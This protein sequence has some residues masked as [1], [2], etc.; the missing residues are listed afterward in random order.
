M[1]ILSKLISAITQPV[2]WLAVW[3]CV[4]LGL[5]SGAARW[6]RAAVRMLWGG[7][8]VLGLLGYGVKT[9]HAPAFFVISV[10]FLSSPWL[11]LSYPRMRVSMVIE[12]G[13]YGPP[14]ES[15]VTNAGVGDDECRR[16][17]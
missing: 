11:L 6:R 3:W 1:F 8:V 15:G 2:F 16:R 4:A 13:R 12:A 10:F 7:L 9:S 14:I 17:G 5:L